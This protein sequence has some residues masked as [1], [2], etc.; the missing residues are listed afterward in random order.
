MEKAAFRAPTKQQLINFRHHIESDQFEVVKKLIWENPRY[1][2]GSG[3]TPTIL[4]EGYRYN[5]MHVCATSRSSK[6]AKLILETVSDPKFAELLLGNKNDEKSCKELNANLLDYYLNMPEKGR[7]ETPL[8]FASKF[9]NIE[10]VE[11]LISYPQCKMLRNSDGNTPTQ[12]GIFVF[13]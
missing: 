8:H 7:N 1:L 3:D 11:I 6:V 9:G 10:I 2:V 12:V 5:A 13:Y 4:K